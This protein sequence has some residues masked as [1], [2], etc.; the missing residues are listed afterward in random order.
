MKKTVKFLFIPLSILLAAAIALTVV[1]A[2]NAS[3]GRYTVTFESNGGTPIESRVLTE[4]AAIERPADPTKALFTFAGW[5]GDEIF[6]EEFDF[7]QKMPAHDVTIYARWTSQRSSRIVFDSMGGSY[8]EPSVGLVGSALTAP[9][10]PVKEGY[11]FGGWY[12]DP[13]PDAETGRPFY[14]VTYPEEN[15]TVYALW[16]DDPAYAYIEYIGN[17]RA[18]GRV[19][20]KLGES[21]AAPDFFHDGGRDLNVVLDGWYL[22][23]DL[24][25]A[26]YEFGTATA[27]ATLYASYYS[28]GMTFADGSGTVTGYTGSDATVFVPNRHGGAEVHLIGERAFAENDAI[29]SVELPSTVIG[30]GNS[31]FYRCRYLDNINLTRRVSSLGSYAFFGCARLT[32]YGDITGASAIPEGLFLGCEKLPAVTL[33]QSVTFIG[34]Q[35]FAD[36][37]V[38]GEIVLPDSVTSIGN[39]A[40]DGCAALRKVALPARLVSIGSDLFTGCVSLSEITIDPSNAVFKIIDGNLYSGTE[41]LRY[42]AGGKGETE[43]VLPDTVTKIAEG[44]FDGVSSLQSIVLGANTA[45]TQGAFAGIRSLESLTL[46]SLG[47]EGYLGYYFGAEG[48]QSTGGY[49]RVIPETLRTLTVLNAGDAI[50]DYAFYGARGLR[51]VNGYEN[52]TSVGRGA[53]AFTSIETFALSEG[54]TSI[55]RLAFEGCPS[56]REFTLPAGSGVYSVYDGCLYNKE[57]TVLLFV[58]CAKTSVEFAP[59][60]DSIA[61]CAFTDSAVGSLVVPDSV[62][63]IAKGAFNHCGELTS[64]TLPFLGDGTPANNY[65]A[66]IFGSSVNITDAN[67]DLGNSYR[68]ISFGDSAALSTVLSEI[69]VKTVSAEIP[70][71]AFAGFVGL[72]EVKYGDAQI[73]KYGAYSFF[74]T[75][76]SAW[77]FTGA[78][79]IGDG[80]FRLGA[81][82]EVVLPVSVRT[83]GYRA[84]AHIRE[85][86]HIELAEG[87]ALTEIAPLAFVAYNSASST[88][89]R[90]TY[91]SSNINEVVV[92]PSNIQKIG[93]AAFY[94]LGMLYG[95]EGNA[96]NAGFGV[97]FAENSA[98]TEIGPQA[99]AHSALRTIALPATVATVGEQAFL[100][101]ESLKTVSFGTAEEQS[102]LATL[103][104]LCF[105]QC[106]SLE[107]LTMN[108]KSVVEMEMTTVTIVESAGSREEEADIFF[109][110]SSGFTVRVPAALLDDFKAAEHWQKYESKLLA[111]A[112]N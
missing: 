43:F 9:T 92:I 60:V 109:A 27:S 57:G 15:V 3:K 90:E 52:A 83:L 46:P 61:E 45:P 37:A 65:L 93:M 35:A 63:S 6:T 16:L 25:G 86:E 77:D 34:A 73:T 24:T 111:I 88:G 97:R 38:L 89:N 91:Y 106:T 22:K 4:G 17:G 108:V 64:L 21:F 68:N 101:C 23:A 19:P 70:D 11:Q 76:V 36:C 112:A 94:G 71:G 74:E 75:A 96:P 31:A 98:L 33:P 95:L 40:F 20:V 7:S 50:A 78:E 84:F 44:A 12:L 32:S 29:V 48:T 47:M 80:A 28:E 87:G 81:L 51:T 59:T 58:P 110:A 72:K 107:T 14:F 30:V 105:A 42:V 99:F 56:F 69:T 2:V 39:G 8:V 82:E 13:D 18:M 26:K 67:D 55:G 10:A 1:L 53:F 102:D 62:T 103:G 41:L 5:Y 66:Y 54:L 104:G 100:G 79:E 49:S 85:L